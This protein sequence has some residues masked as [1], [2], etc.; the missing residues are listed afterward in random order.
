MEQVLIEEVGVNGRVAR[1][2]MCRVVFTFWAGLAIACGAAH[3]EQ[4]SISAW[5]AADFRA[6]SFVPYWTS[7]SQLNLFPADGMYKHVSD[8]LYFSGVQPTSSGNLAY[9]SAATQHLA[10]LKSQ[11]A[12]NGFRLHMSMRD[13]SG[14]SEEFVWNSITSNATNRANF[15][16][17]VK[18]LLTANNMKGFNLDWER[19]NSVAQWAN[20]TQL[21]KD[22]RAAINPLGMEVSVDDYGFADSQWDDSPVFDARTYDQLFIMGYHYPAFGGGSLNQN[23]F[24]NGKLALTAQGATKAFKNEQ[25]VIGIGTWGAPTGGQSIKTLKEIAA[26]NPNLPFDAGTFT[27][28]GNTWTI[29]S[30]AQV[31]DKVQLALDRNMAGMMYWTLHYDATNNLGL[32]RVAHHYTVFRRNVPD[33]NLDGRVD[34]ADANK[35]AD[36][37]GTVAGW[38][39]TNTPA[40]LDTFYLRG[41]WEKGD[42]DGNAYVNQQ[43]ADWLAGRFAALD[44]TLPDRLAYTGTFERFT[45]SNGLTGS[46]QAVRNG[47]GQLPETGNF[48]QHGA[49]F[50]SFAGTGP[51]ATLHSNIS[52]TLRNQNAAE[53]VDAINTAPRTM[54]AALTEPIDLAQNADTY[55]TFLIRQ[56]TGPLLASHVTSPSRTLALE[57]L[58]SAGANQ[59][60][61]AFHGQ[62]QQFAIRSQAD[63]AGDDVSAGGFA[64][65]STYLFVGK[66]A[67]NGTRTNSIQ[68][69]L[70]PSGTTIGRFIDPDFDWMLT[71][72]SS[73][74]FDPIITQLEFNGL[75][76]ANYTVSNVWI[77]GAHQFFALTPTDMGDFNTDGT[78]DAADYVV[79]RRGLGTSYTPAYYEAWRTNF[80]LTASTLGSATLAGGSAVPAVPEPQSWILPLA[81]MFTIWSLRCRV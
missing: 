14:G 31:R 67:G 40:R 55:V 77:G 47:L 7:Q 42:R 52:V 24:A 62:Q 71:A 25:L 69:S 64:P 50:L 41:N 81:G 58:D 1:G 73:E 53:A 79:W 21:A 60:D 13:P 12:A 8:V 29:E 66:I 28:G 80:G 70:F 17:N 45:D 27:Q 18:N 19:P 4:A 6:W 22:L 76:E 78:V 23:S 46:W 48:A 5:D 43:D 36:G 3:A 57:F 54:R 10:T 38:T 63:A 68:A 26:A 37:M 33:L 44:V 2:S 30:R 39:G 34:A 9:L 65:D 20:Y 35:L 74:G 56:N 49:S 16:A 75:Y 15:V 32:H 61:F 11:A 51:G 59:F 72:G